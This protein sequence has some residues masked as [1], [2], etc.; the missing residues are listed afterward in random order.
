MLSQKK[1]AEKLGL[2]E[3]T[4]SR[5]VKERKIPYFLLNGIVRFDE[6]VID[7]WIQKRTVRQKISS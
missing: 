2:S 7:S 5:W 1:V 6:K 3:A 4:I